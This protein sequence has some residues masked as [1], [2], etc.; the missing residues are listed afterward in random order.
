[1]SLAQAEVSDVDMQT[2]GRWKDAK[3]LSRVKSLS[4]VP[5]RGFVLGAS[6]S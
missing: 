5:E 1:M 3:M 4:A 6:L 2:A